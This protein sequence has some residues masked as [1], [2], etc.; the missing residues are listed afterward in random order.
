MDVES[1]NGPHEFVTNVFWQN[2]R[3]KY[4]NFMTL[5]R[6]SIRLVFL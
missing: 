6:E 1:K 4:S 5:E 3:K 2:Q